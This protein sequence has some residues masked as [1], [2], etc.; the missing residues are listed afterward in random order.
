MAVRISSWN[1]L[2]SVRRRSAITILERRQGLT[3]KVVAVTFDDGPAQWTPQILDLLARYEAQS[4]FFVIGEHVEQRPEI[5]RQTVAAGHELGNHT[6]THP[7]LTET[8]DEVIRTE[9]RRTND[10]V[11]AVAACRPRFFRPPFLARDERV[12]RI[13]A[14][15]GFEAVVLFSVFSLDWRLESSTAI[16]DNVLREVG[17]GAI[18]G[19]HDGRPARAENATLSRQPTVEALERILGSLAADGYRM[20]TVSQLLE[21]H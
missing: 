5:V 6:F 13:A 1:R 15:L 10:A 17:P 2:S 18:A 3:D 19:L 11:E 4:T 12:D 8:P 16:A 20:V 9:L 14:E 7:R 21:A